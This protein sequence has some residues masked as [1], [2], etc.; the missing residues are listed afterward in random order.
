MSKVPSYVLKI[1]P[2]SEPHRFSKFY[3][4]SSS[5]EPEHRSV[6]GPTGW[7]DRSGSI[8]KTL[9]LRFHYIYVCMYIH[10]ISPSY[11]VYLSLIVPFKKQKMS[12][13][14][15]VHLLIK[16]SKIIQK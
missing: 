2:V 8:F 7:T 15:I 1:G 4:F 14:T 16:F 11:F 9:V 10:V 12:L 5:L 13:E 6:N 3:Q